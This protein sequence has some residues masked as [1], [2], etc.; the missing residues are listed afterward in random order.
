R[1]RFQS[2]IRSLRSSTRPPAPLQ[3]AAPA[4]RGPGSVRPPSGFPAPPRSKPL[5]EFPETPPAAASSPATGKSPPG[6]AGACN[7]ASPPAA[8]HPCQKRTPPPAVNYA[9]NFVQHPRDY[10]SQAAAFVTLPFALDLVAIPSPRSNVP[11]SQSAPQ[12]CS[13]ILSAARRVPSPPA[14]QSLKPSS[15]P[16]SRR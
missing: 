5:P 12:Q 2:R 9:A 6:R 16:A 11:E 10:K 4:R 1:P 7:P 14:V 13:D 3:L 15:P 8:G